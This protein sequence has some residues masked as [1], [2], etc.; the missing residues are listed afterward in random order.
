MFGCGKKVGV[1]EAPEDMK[2]TIIGATAIEEGVGNDV[3]RGRARSSV[4]QV[5]G[6]DEAFCPI[7]RRHAGMDEKCAN[8][9]VEHADDMLS[10]AILL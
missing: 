2:V 10:L 7:L 8:D 4:K 1:A 9:V 3:V 5:G 6:S